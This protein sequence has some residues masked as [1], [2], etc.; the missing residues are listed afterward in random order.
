MSTR[1]T[2]LSTPFLVALLVGCGGGSGDDWQAPELAPCEQALTAA[3]VP[4]ATLVN[5][6]SISAKYV[7]PDGSV[8]IEYTNGLTAGQSGY[9][10]YGSCTFVGGKLASI[11]LPG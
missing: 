6:N 11:K 10:F 8:L 2:I 3:G 9:R 5:P 7:Q 1:N 4:A